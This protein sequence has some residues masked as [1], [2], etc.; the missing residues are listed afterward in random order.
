[1]INDSVEKLDRPSLQTE[2]SVTPKPFREELK[3]DA[4]I[5]SIDTTLFF[6][7]SM[8]SCDENFNCSDSRAILVGL[9]HPHPCHKVRTN[10]PNDTL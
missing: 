3:P 6:E 2:H 9:A 4:G 7:Y 5:H 1:M 8:G 10:L